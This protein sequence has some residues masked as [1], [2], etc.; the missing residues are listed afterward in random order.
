M[1]VGVSANWSSRVAKE[2]LSGVPAELLPAALLR[3]GSG[4]GGSVGGESSSSSSSGR[5]VSPTIGAP[6]DVVVLPLFLGPSETVTTFC[7]KEIRRARALHP[8]LRVRIGPPLVCPCPYGLLFFPSLLF[9][10]VGFV[11][12]ITSSTGS[13]FHIN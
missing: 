8:R 10:S 7:P 1:V 13:V 6:I 4:D 9:G 2:D 12:H 5:A 11:D 3:L